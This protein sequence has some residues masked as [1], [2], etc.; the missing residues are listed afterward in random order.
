[1]DYR[2]L[3]PG[4]R[5]QVFVADAAGRGQELVYESADLL[6][7]AP[8]WT[9]DGSAL[10]LNGHGVLWRL[11]LASRALTPVE[12]SGI[13]ALNNDHVLAPDGETIYLSA[14]DGHIYRAPLA[15]GAAERITNDGAPERSFLHGVSPDGS[16]LAYVGVEAEGNDPW[17]RANI[18][19]IPA[20]GG[21]DVPLTDGRAP[22]DGCEYSP[23]GRWIYFNTE[24]FSD[25]PGHAQI[26]RMRPDG[27]DPEQLTFDEEVNWFPHWAPDGAAAVY[28]SFPPGTTGHPANLPVALKVVVE[29]AWT[30][31]RTV[32]RLFG[33]QGTINVNS[34]SP[35]SDRFAYVAYP[36]E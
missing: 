33:G 18:W 12:V 29:D 9:L 30:D 16:T 8:N 26:A 21:A 19:T 11:D 28:L 17:A 24:Q 15:G 2:T 1:M 14:N 13:P 25:V 35:D 36:M 34:W 6:L 23:D 7:E 4:Q 32:V 5:C 31:P 3:V 10:I 27:S 22:R 20:A